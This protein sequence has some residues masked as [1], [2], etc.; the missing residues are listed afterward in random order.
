MKREKVSDVTFGLYEICRQLV[1]F[2]DFRIDRE[3]VPEG[4]TLY[5]IRHDD[6]GRGTPC[7]I[8]NKVAV[9]FYGTILCKHPIKMTKSEYGDYRNI[10]RKN[11]RHVKPRVT[12]DEY[13]KGEYK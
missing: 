2:T 13:M 1:L 9:N 6:N 7:T 5:E 3:T 10:S 4:L 8:E 11:F 12:V